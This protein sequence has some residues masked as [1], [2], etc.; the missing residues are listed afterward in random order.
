M[1]SHT[2]Q[3]FNSDVDGADI[4]RRSGVTNKD[5]SLLWARN[6][7]HGIAISSLGSMLGA[8]QYTQNIENQGQTALKASMVR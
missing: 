7:G 2:D 5:Q 1:T 6:P 4:H 3:R 8:F